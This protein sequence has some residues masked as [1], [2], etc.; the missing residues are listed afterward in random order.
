MMGTYPDYESIKL[1]WPAEHVLRVT[2]SRGKVN[3]MDYQLHHDIAHIWNLIAVDTDVNVV[4]VTGAGKY[5]SA[6]GD[7]GTE[8][9]M[10]EDWDLLN[11]ML[12]DARAIVDNMIRFDKPV[13]AAINGPAAGGGLTVA[14][15]SDITLMARSTKIVDAHT[16]LGIGAGDHSAMVWPLLCGMAKAKYYL[17][18]CDP[19]TAD[20]AEEIGL[21]TKAVDDDKLMDEA[22]ALAARLAK[23]APTALR[24]TKRSINQWF[25]ML[26]PIYENSQVYSVLGYFGPDLPEGLG[27]HM[28]K[29]APNFNPRSTV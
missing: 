28:E 22:V 29:R 7:F 11:G 10:Q 3:S 14:L 17:S 26:W 18:T 25:R 24:Y 19:I 13:I 5:F 16:R 4:I 23:G 15:M 2:M 8:H 9:A 27:A 1:D 20:V 12:N 21:I 6:G